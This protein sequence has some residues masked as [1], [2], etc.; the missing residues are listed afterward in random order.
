MGS[1][2]RGK[3]Y[4]LVAVHWRPQRI[5]TIWSRRSLTW[6][7]LIAARVNHLQR[8]ARDRNLLQPTKKYCSPTPGTHPGQNR[9]LSETPSFLKMESKARWV[10]FQRWETSFVKKTPRRST[11]PKIQWHH[12]RLKPTYPAY[13]ATSTAR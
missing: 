7:L 8:Q 5:T 9:S 1:T 2:C 4:R 6:L 10:R 12:S 13:L 11:L 3:C